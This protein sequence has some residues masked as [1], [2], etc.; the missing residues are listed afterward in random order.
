MLNKPEVP[1]DAT[2]G[3]AARNSRQA[4]VPFI[5]VTV[6]LDVIGFGLIIPVLPL[7]VGEFTSSREAQAYYYGLL[8]A[9]FG[10]MQ[11]IC[12]PFL[13]ALSDRFGRRSVLLI[14]IFGLGLNFMVTA[15]AT[16]LTMLFA[17]RLIG[18][19]MSANLAV[20]NAYI[21]DVTPPQDRARRFGM[22]GASFGIG[23]IV[24]PM[25]GG[26][27]GNYG[28]RWPFFAAAGLSLL[29]WIYGLLVLPES[30]PKERRSRFSMARANPVSS[31]M[32]LVQIKGIS[33]LVIVI[34]LSAMAQFILHSTWVLYTG[35]RFDWGPREVGFSLFVVG[36]F[37]ALVQGVFLGRLLGRF[38]A[39]RL[40]LIGLTTGALCYTA[41][42]L[43][44]EGWM[45]YVIMLFNCLTSCVNPSLQSMVS[46][47]VGPTKQGITM[48][49]ISSLNSI[50]T[51]ISTLAGA[52]LFAQVTHLEHD[53]WRVGAPFFLGGGLLLLAL[54]LAL[55][56]FSRT[57]APG[58]VPAHIGA[59]VSTNASEAL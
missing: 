59:S 16:S 42:G 12:A 49:A 9:S 33:L 18:G 20:A 52:T 54:I 41:Y 13:G 22:I 44:T 19:A 17:G 1:L 35:F 29:N 57:P 21:A 5:M 43:V 34:T 46:Q 2:P 26:I 30:L 27:L 37:T 7:L 8:V 38:G 24:G 36:V 32:H 45:M 31:L 6:L 25:M 55:R 11:F 58:S 3:V 15:L 51:V 40:A 23:F 14:G 56:H 10:V 53:D 50:T 4:A 48:G 47:A 28:A 39:R